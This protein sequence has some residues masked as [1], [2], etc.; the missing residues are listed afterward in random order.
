VRTIADGAPNRYDLGRTFEIVVGKQPNQKSF[1]AYHDLLIQRSD[2][3]RAA[4]SERWSQDPTKPTTLDDVD[5]EIFSTYLHC[6]NWGA[7]FLDTPVQTLLDENRRLYEK[8]TSIKSDGD[9]SSGGDNT[10]GS[11]DDSSSDDESS[12][13]S[14]SGDESTAADSDE[15]DRR[16]M[17]SCWPV[18][19][20][21]IDLYLLADKLIDPTT[22]NLA[23]DKL[24][25]VIGERNKYLTQRM[26]RVVYRSTTVDSP[27]RR[28]V[29]DYSTIDDVVEGCN[30]DIHQ[31][32]EFSP[33]FVK[34]V[35]LEFMAINKRN[36]EGIVGEVYRCREL[37]PTDYHQVV[38][39]TSA[40]DTS[41]AKHEV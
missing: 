2:F 17:K 5:V 23:I 10:K 13:G 28:L 11:D 4:R 30:L 33:E 39:K 7:E 19:T 35:L 27:L 32:G 40:A 14:D 18:E 24:I 38:D 1:T 25:D 26:I 21:L 22:A 8:E 31:N 12:D 34:D 6:V 3:F 29:R 16:I 15:E 41:A 36:A 37:Q 9:S 20:F